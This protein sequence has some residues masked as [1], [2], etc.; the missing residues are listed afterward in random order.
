MVSV[1]ALGSSL[2]TAALAGPDMDLCSLEIF[3]CLPFVLN[4][5]GDL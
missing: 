2:S 4:E 3:S 5:E 1:R